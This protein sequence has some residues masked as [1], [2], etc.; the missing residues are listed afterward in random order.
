MWYAI[1]LGGGLL[2][3]VGFLIWA[4][5]ERTL[6]HEAERK[7]DAATAAERAALDALAAANNTVD[8]QGGELSRTKAQV[9]TVRTALDAARKKLVMCQDGPTVKAWLDEQLKDEKL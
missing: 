7:A 6:R 2:V 8:M 3:G 4:L 5:K 9:E 1:A